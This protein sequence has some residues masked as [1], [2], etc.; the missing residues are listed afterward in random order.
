MVKKLSL[1]GMLGDILWGVVSPLV[2]CGCIRVV[3]ACL[4]VWCSGMDDE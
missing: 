3:P 1:A 4:I 2:S